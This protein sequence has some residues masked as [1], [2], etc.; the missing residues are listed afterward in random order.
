[1]S[2]G[3]VSAGLL[4]DIMKQEGYMY[5]LP[6]FLTPP[7]FILDEKYICDV[8][9]GYNVELDE[10]GAQNTGMISYVDH[11]AFTT[12]RNLLENRGYI[13]TQRNWSNGDVVLHDFW[14]NDWYFQSGDQFP[15]AAA[16]GNQLKCAKKKP[17][18]YEAELNSEYLP[19]RVPW[20]EGKVDNE[21]KLEW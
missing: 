13:K 18:L 19:V 12:L 1:M 4:F 21:E 20:N 15:C 5:Q 6:L 2:W 10:Y 3:G 8:Y 9:C 16:M 14:L 7:E 11:P 17:E